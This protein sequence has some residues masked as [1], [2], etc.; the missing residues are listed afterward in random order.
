MNGPDKIT[1]NTDG[2]S[3]EEKAT[4]KFQSAYKDMLAQ[5]TASGFIPV[6]CA[7]EA[8]HAIY[9]TLAGMKNFEP[10]PARIRWDSE[11]NDYKGYLAAIQVLDLPPW[12]PGEF[13]NWL[14]KIARGHAAG[15]VIA[16][17]FMPSSDGGDKD[18][19]ERFIKLCDEIQKADP[20]VRIDSEDLWKKA[21]DSI[22]EE[23]KNPANLAEV[24]KHAAML[25]P[26]FG[27]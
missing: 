13:W 20:K 25:R 19:K 16:R 24:E 18:D 4:E 2:I 22:V 11:I 10:L 15:G 12:T 5:L 21:Q 7:H 17:K 8:G 27:L 6:L 23:L 9:F 3:D 1:I 14:F 26:L